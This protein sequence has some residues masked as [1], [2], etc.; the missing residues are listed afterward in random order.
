MY[1]LERQ[2][3]AGVGNLA[4][5]IVSV[6]A[7]YLVGVVFALS[8][9]PNLPHADKLWLA[10]PLPM[11]AILAYWVQLNAIALVRS[12]TCGELEAEI[13][14]SAPSLP[15]LYGVK[16]A[17]R[18]TDVRCASWW[19]RP[20]AWVSNGYAALIVGGLVLTCFVQALSAGASWTWTLAFSVLYVFGL[21]S[22]LIAG[23]GAGRE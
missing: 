2:D 1:A 5:T 11:V 4:L 20:S 13:R 8:Q 16:M 6:G 7:A 21:L 22:A 19:Y 12:R 9:N 23:I 17:A 15:A 3:V 10:A 14:R 18:V